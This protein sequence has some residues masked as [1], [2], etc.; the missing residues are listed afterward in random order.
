[1]RKVVAQLEDSGLQ[2]FPCLERV[3]EMRVG[4]Q[5]TSIRGLE[6]SLHVRFRF[7]RIDWKILVHEKGEAA[8]RGHVLAEAKWMGTYRRD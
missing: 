1:L 8:M 5:H 4:L 7:M 6:L 3:E 2:R